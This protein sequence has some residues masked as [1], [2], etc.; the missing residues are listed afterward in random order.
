MKD[1]VFIAKL[2]KRPLKVVY[3]YMCPFCD[4]LGYPISEQEF[5]PLRLP[6]ETLQLY[7]C[8]LG[9]TFFVRETLVKDQSWAEDRCNNPDMKR[10]SSFWKK[11]L[12][13]ARYGVDELQD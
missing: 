13:Q 11:Q 5:K 6:D 8:M 9:H 12:R 3:P 2:K 7:K 10:K 1:K 4:E